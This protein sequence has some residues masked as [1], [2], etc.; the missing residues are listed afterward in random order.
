MR[1][2]ELCIQRPIFTLMLVSAPV[3]MGLA[4]Y[5]R[6]GVDLFPN[7]DLPTT[8]VTTTLKG[9]GV[10]EMETSVTKLIEETVNTI[11]GIDE[12]RSA[13]K[14][15]FS[16][17]I[18]QFD[19]F[20]DGDIAA[21]EVRD[22]VSSI[23]SQLPVGTDPPLIDKF[24]LDASPVMTLAISGKRNFREVTEIARKQ[25]KENLETVGGVGAVTLVGGLKRAIN[26][27]IDTDK[28]VGFRLS[29]DDVR[30]ALIRQNL[31]L[32]GGRVD[33]GSKE[34]VLR[35]M[36]RLDKS[37]DFDELI[38]AD[39]GG[40]PVRVKDIGRVEDSFEEP[41]GLSRLDGDN[42]VSLIIQKQ[43]GKNTVEVVHAVK[44]R[45]ASI[46]DTLPADIQTV[47]IR[48]Q[49]RFIEASIE[50]VQFHLL[51]AAVLVS[52]TILLFIRDWRTTIIAT[53]AIPTSMVPTFACMYYM[54]FTLNNIT[55]LGLILAIGI[56]IDD[57]VVV[58]ENIFRHME[59]E[60]K[61]AMEASN[62]ATAEIAGAVVATTI[63]LLVIF[64]PVAFMEGRVG[65]FFNSFGF[66]VGFA[67][68][69][70]M[71]VSFTMTPM[72][73]SRFLVLEKGHKTSKE[74]FF[75]R[76]IDG[77]YL[78][79]LRFSL[80]HRWVIILATVL[81]LLSTPVIFG[82]IGK[83]FVPKDDQSEMEIAMTLP[84]GYTLERGD[85]VLKEIEERLKKLRG[86]THVFTIIG[87]T[88]GRVAK[89]QGDVTQANIYC[90][91][92]DLKE[93][94][95]SQFDVMNDAR[96]LMRDYPDLRS[97]VQEVS[98]IQAT[99][100]RQVDIDLNLVGPDFD[101]LQSYADKIMDY[102][103]KSGHYVDIDTSLSISKPELRVQI[104]RER[105]SDLSIPVRTIAS[106]L[107]ILV[108]G[109]PVSKYKEADE[110]YDVWLRAEKNFRDDPTS[111]DTMTIPSEKV[112]LVRLSNVA[113]LEPA[114]GPTTINRYGRMR[115]LV[116][117]GNLKG[118]ALGEGIEELDRFVRTLNL[119]T[120]YHHE[121]IGRAKLLR[122]SNSNFLVAFL[123]SFL[124]MYMVLAAQFE[125]LVHPITIMLALPLTLPFA[126][127]SLWLLR[128]NLDVY[129]IFGLF[130]LFG[131][132]KKN[133]ILQIDYTN[134]LR[135][136][137]MERDAAIMEANKTR[138]RPILM[139]T[140]MLIAA[141]V[142]IALGQGP[143]AGS[144]ASMAKVIIGG[145]ALSLLL[146]L[147]VTPVAYS[148][149][150]DFTAII[151]RR[152]S[153]ARP[154]PLAAAEGST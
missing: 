105:A 80:R 14:E 153:V 74:G 63:S 117:I 109:E 21:Q 100:F 130:M 20:K 57:A 125:S 25:I 114:L 5:P 3:V 40:F 134:V 95:Y 108:G 138:L 121:F 22:K 37:A 71:F 107:G 149:W 111:V 82:M 46:R 89:G 99:G 141:M 118:I 61:D 58:H 72:L 86:V 147:L 38:I 60:G 129:A 27:Y 94:D 154:Q 42:A 8:V 152:L 81:T 98:A 106:T 96:L 135:G 90:R 36:G 110:Q 77:S 30:Q 83:D 133:G 150:D 45:L 13:T 52:L 142:P 35:T 145:Q 62:S 24:D 32:P 127:L 66:T 104:D 59:E 47:V 126:F 9:A 54:G 91:L 102:M 123:L 50:E 53:L 17:V 33:Q 23:L 1:I 92:V 88:T 49:S 48:D 16:Q 19:L 67:I 132:V 151:R 41:R 55:M 139:T 34:L 12:L 120:G 144:R 2:W 101:V 65:R 131:I 39:R 128:T 28:L 113:K 97:A 15:G 136:R 93:R 70:S 11:S 29:A 78:A 18:I 26:I 51:L 75:T 148:L 56:V 31:E 122:E 124:F 43:S 64:I 116:V 119:P 10:E 137:G 140:L 87:D 6:L 103:R 146:T 69:A 4:A 79:I 85:K 84:E 115:Q 73:C 68:M 143:G 76:I 44:A 112:G 7:V